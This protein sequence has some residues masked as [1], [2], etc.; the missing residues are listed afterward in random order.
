MQ[1]HRQVI[2]HLN[3]QCKQAREGFVVFG[4][5]TKLEPSYWHIWCIKI[6]KNGIG[7]RKLL[8]PKVEIQKNKHRMLQTPI[9][10]HPVLEHPKNSLYVVML[11]LKFQNEL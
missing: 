3:V 2:G 11:L 5:Q 6:I 10:E 1:Q 9:L 8:A 7:L 4:V